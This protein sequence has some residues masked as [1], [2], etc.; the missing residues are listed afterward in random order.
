MRKNMGCCR[1]GT[2][3]IHNDIYPRDGGG[4]EE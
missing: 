1:Y 2:D 3:D 4:F